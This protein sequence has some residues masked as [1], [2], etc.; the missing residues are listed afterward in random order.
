MLRMRA[1]CK[2][3]K[4]MWLWQI[5]E[6]REKEELGRELLTGNFSIPE[7]KSLESRVNDYEVRL[8]YPLFQFLVNKRRYW[9]SFY[10]F[11]QR[12]TISF[13]PII[14]LLILLSQVFLSHPFPVN[15][16]RSSWDTSHEWYLCCFCV[17][18]NEDYCWWEWEKTL[19]RL[20][21]CSYHPTHMCT[22][23]PSTLVSHIQFLTTCVSRQ[24][25]VKESQGEQ[26]KAYH[27][28]CRGCF[29]SLDKW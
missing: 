12:K 16:A 28:R 4:A 5:L 10:L 26:E 18:G 13:N 19:M 21:N 7:T 22:L 8:K 3:S 1:K 17:R 15:G 23:T 11:V 6:D 14:Q 20:H 27:G 24:I 29:N 2:Y 9:G 25:L